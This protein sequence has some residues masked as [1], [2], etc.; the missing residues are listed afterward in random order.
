MANTLLLWSER[1][2]W[3]RAE[4]HLTVREDDPDLPNLL[5]CGRWERHRQLYVWLGVACEG[6]SNLVKAK[7]Y[8]GGIPIWQSSDVCERRLAL[9]SNRLRTLVES[10]DRMRLLN[11]LYQ[12]VH[13]AC[14][15]S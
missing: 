7:Q 5:Q 8:V 13:A 6:S 4:S 10:A 15:A 9:A 11:Q 14:R 12:G 1:V 3:V 2:Q